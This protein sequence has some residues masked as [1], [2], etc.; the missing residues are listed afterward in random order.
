MNAALNPD[1]VAWSDLFQRAHREHGGQPVTASDL[2]PLVEN[3]DAILAMLSSKDPKK[4]LSIQLRKIV[5]RVY[6]GVRLTTATK[7]QG[8]A[9]FKFSPVGD[10]CES[11]DSLSESARTREQEPLDIGDARDTRAYGPSEGFN[12]H[13]SHNSHDEPSGIESREVTL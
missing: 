4:S 2:W 3:D 5:G 13:N 12:S 11:C 8:F 1:D 9:R 6:V 7:S 10:S